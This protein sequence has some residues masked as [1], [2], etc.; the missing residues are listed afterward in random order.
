MSARLDQIT[1]HLADMHALE[2][3]ILEAVERQRG[4]DTVR[5]HIHVNKALIEIERV[6]NEHTDHL[7]R[8]SQDYGSEG[9][10][11]FKKAV[12]TV[13]GIAAGLYD[14]VRDDTMTRMLRDDYTALSLTAM[15]YTAMHAFAL[16]IKETRMADVALTHLKHITPL[17]VEISKIIPLT[18]VE[19]TATDH[20]GFAVDTTVGDEAVRN[21][22]RAWDR[23]V[24]ASVA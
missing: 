2:K 13:A 4:N 12:T 6:L 24:T 10:S 5:N 7:A 18:T 11:M 8:M 19:E 20:D 9:E 23:D 3:H 22:Q 15:G 21:T 16:A 1:K 14:Q 17:L